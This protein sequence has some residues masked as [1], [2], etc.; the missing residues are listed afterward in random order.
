MIIKNMAPRPRASAA[1]VRGFDA[2][3][4]KFNINGIYTTLDYEHK[5]LT[6]LC[7]YRFLFL[8]S[9]TMWNGAFERKKVL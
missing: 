9:L 4:D 1:A 7:N 8:D 2:I 6:Q 3:S 5:W